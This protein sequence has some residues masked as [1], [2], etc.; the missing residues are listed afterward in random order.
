[1]IMMMRVVTMCVEEDAMMMNAECLFGIDCVDSLL[2]E[3]HLECVA[4]SFICVR[5]D[6]LLCFLIAE[7][8]DVQQK[9]LSKQSYK[10]CAKTH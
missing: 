9:S 6:E 4:A 8:A 3:T 7:I 5:N 1:M 2:I 10:S